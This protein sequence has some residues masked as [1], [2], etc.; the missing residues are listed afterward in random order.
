MW[1]LKGILN[2]SPSSCSTNDR[3]LEFTHTYPKDQ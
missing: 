2:D 3:A 1:D